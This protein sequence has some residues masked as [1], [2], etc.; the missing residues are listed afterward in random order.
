MLKIIIYKVRYYKLMNILNLPNDIFYQIFKNININKFFNLELVN[1]DL[2][3]LIKQYILNKYKYKYSYN[4]L[5]L[6]LYNFNNN[7]DFLN[8]ILFSKSSVLNKLVYHTNDLKFRKLIKTSFIINKVDIFENKDLIYKIINI[9]Y[10]LFNQILLHINTTYLIF[11]DINKYRKYNNSSYIY[12]NKEYTYK[13]F[14]EFI[15]IY[16]YLKYLNFNKII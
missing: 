1:Y 11:V 10:T 8:K 15:K 9:Y 6:N 14:Y 12:I 4:N 5:K 16:K 3:I 7:I 13:N 2:N